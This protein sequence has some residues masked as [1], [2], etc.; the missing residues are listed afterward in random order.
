[1]KDKRVVPIRSVEEKA[2]KKRAPGMILTVFGQ[3]FQIESNIRI[4]E[5]PPRRSGQVFPIRSS[6][7]PENNS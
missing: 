7:K 6:E 4:T 3:R 5:L 1:M 2:L